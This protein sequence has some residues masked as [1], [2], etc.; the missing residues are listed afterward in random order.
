M[1]IN[2]IGV[3]G[4]KDSTALLLWAIYESGYPKESL[5]VTFC[6]TGNENKITLDYVKMLSEKVFPIETIYPEKPF[7]DACLEKKIFPSSRRRFCTQFQK[8]K[9]ALKHVNKLRA[10]GNELLLHSGVRASESEDR[11][12]LPIKGFDGFFGCDVFRP[13]LNWTIEDVWE[14]HRKHGIE[15]NPLYKMGMKRVGC[16]P[17]VLCSKEE[18][19]LTA[20]LF[21][22][23]IKNIR[24][25]EKRL[26]KK[27]GRPASF[28]HAKTTTE[29]F[30]SVD[31]ITNDGSKIKVNTI[32]DVVLWSKTV[33][34]GKQFGLDLTT[35]D[36]FGEDDFKSCPSAIGQC[37]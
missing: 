13:L 23:R 2:H 10:S 3:S 1:K 37:E 26:T 17:C 36:D 28:F 5:N 14:I 4:G 32:D 7:F 20:K 22:E 24:K 34:G 31:Y 30:R 29:N 12:N 9:P 11:A 25:W 18:V 33:H 8:M 27:Q 16:S 21:P 19:R 6:D 15:P 35:E